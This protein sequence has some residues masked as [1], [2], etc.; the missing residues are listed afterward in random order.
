MKK[1]YNFG[2]KVTV[3]REHGIISLVAIIPNYSWDKYLDYNYHVSFRDGTHIELC[4]HKLEAG[5]KKND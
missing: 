5:W 4:Y 3:D 1:R 2:D